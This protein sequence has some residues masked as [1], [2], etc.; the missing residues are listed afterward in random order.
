[1]SGF[2]G[3][4]NGSERTPCC[5]GIRHLRNK[6]GPP[7]PLRTIGSCL[8]CHDGT[9]ADPTTYIAPAEHRLAA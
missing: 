6:C 4:P 2:L 7:V 8:E 9:P 5:T 3:R 1:P